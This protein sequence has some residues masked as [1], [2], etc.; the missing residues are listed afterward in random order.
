MS[1]E[2]SLTRDEAVERAAL[3]EVRRYDIDVDLTGLLDGVEWRATSR[4]TFDCH[5]P[6]ADSFVDCLGEIGTATLNGR[7]LD[8]ASAVD[9]RLPLPALE[10]ENVLEVSSV[11]HDTASSAGILRS[12]DPSDG[13]VYVWTSFEADDARRA[14]A[15]FDQP[16]LKAPHAFTVT[17]PE[18]WVVTS[19]TG[20]ESVTEPAD[21]ARVWSFPDTPPLSTYVVVV[22][23]G[24]F[25]EIREQRGGHSLGLF[26]RQSMR[27]FLERDAAELFEVTEQ[28]LAFFAER[29]DRPFAQE[30]YDH[31]FVPNMGGAMENWGCVTWS[32][33][34]L[35]R[36]EPTRRMREGTANILLHEMAHMWFGDLVTMRWW[37][38]LWLNE[39]FASWAA[40]WAQ[41]EATRYTEA[42]ASFLIGFKVE[43]YRLDMGPATHPV[44]GDVPTVAHGIAN[45]DAIS[46]VKGCSVLKQLAAYVG[47][48]AFVAGL[49]DYFATYAWQ[50]TTLEDFLGAIGSAAGRDLG[51]WGRRWLREA[52]TDTLRVRDGGLLAEGPDGGSPRPHRLN[53]GIFVDRGDVLERVDAVPVE[54][55]GTTTPLPDLP[56]GALVLPNDSD[57]TFAAVRPDEASLATL[58][59]RAGDL[60]DALA[61]GLAVTMGW[62]MLARGELTGAQMMR[63]VLDVLRTE[64]TAGLVEAHLR[65]ALRTATLWVPTPDIDAHLADLAAACRELA[66]VPELRS[67]A[68]KTLAACARTEEDFA[69]LASDDDVDLAWRV[70]V[71]RADLGQYDEAAVAAL[72][73]RDPDPD[74]WVRALGVRCAR[75]ESAAKDEAWQAVFVDRRVPAGT[76]AIELAT[77]LWRPG[78]DELLRPYVMRYLDEL[79]AIDRGGMLALGVITRAMFPYQSADAGFLDGA[80]EL[81]G[82]EGLLPAV[83][84]SLLGA[85]DTLARMLRQR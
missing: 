54:T 21:A 79:A 47:E 17:A 56:A 70:L 39:A 36:S 53:L 30:R 81:V 5:S 9:G 11:Q 69:L 2:R 46:Y 57:L 4:V 78:Q 27:P 75:P 23:A 33:S 38:D 19:N 24:P 28:G 22:N 25:H 31:V 60:D 44:R 40:S 77:C 15:C 66:D 58:L 55:T 50:N 10:A 3:L 64:R 1:T 74:S 20:P 82:R 72:Q 8:P 71:R 14:W 76:P 68:L 41:A 65:L 48:E 45:F 67:A 42:W 18:S 16:D 85:T 83:R 34:S 26:C 59:E 35:H 80:R 32:D 43:G 29:F 62:D 37:D 12:V 51:D 61:R 6:G 49:R 52:G 7:P 63:L 73:A 84:Q 13:L